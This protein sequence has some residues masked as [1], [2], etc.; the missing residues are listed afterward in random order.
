MEH[1]CLLFIRM[2]ALIPS[3]YV[4]SFESSDSMSINQFTVQALH[5]V[6]HGRNPDFGPT[7]TR[8]SYL[9]MS[10]HFPVERLCFLSPVGFFLFGSSRT[11]GLK[12]RQWCSSWRYFRTAKL[13]LW[14]FKVNEIMLIPSLICT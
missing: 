14:C 10:N 2:P 1:L 12:F 5:T 7:G 6:V 9:P 13:F 4:G 11:V 8:A 3:Q